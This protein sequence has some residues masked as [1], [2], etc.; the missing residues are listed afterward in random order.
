MQGEALLI[1]LPTMACVGK[2]IPSKG[3]IDISLLMA[4]ASLVMVVAICCKVLS[5]RNQL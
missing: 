3:T 4:D 5:P 2:L 1:T